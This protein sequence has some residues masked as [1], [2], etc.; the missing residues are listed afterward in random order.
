MERDDRR[1]GLDA[2]A[3]DKLPFLIDVDFGDQDVVLTFGGDLI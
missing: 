2:K 3:L 1:H